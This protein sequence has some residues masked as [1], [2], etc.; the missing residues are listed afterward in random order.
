M[1]IP[2]SSTNLSATQ[3]LLTQTLSGRHECDATTFVFFSTAIATRVYMESLIWYVLRHAWMCSESLHCSNFPSYDSLLE[4]RL[5]IRR[6]RPKGSPV[7]L[8]SNEASLSCSHLLCH[9]NSLLLLLRLPMIRFN[10]AVTSNI[11]FF[12]RIEALPTVKKYMES[13][14]YMKKGP[15]N[16]K[17]A[18]WGPKALE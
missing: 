16:N 18:S 11:S 7:V 10:L 1:I 14:S 2:A 15:F 17:I 5:N 13:S 4:T 6:Q 8:R 12:C 3:F 9:L